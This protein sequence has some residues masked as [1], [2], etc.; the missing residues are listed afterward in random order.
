MF[1]IAVDIGGTFT[2]CVVADTD[3]DRTLS[4]SLTTHGSLSDGVLAA[5]DVN[6]T[7]RG[8]TVEALLR[9]TSLFVHGTTVGTNAVLT[10]TGAKT[11]LITTMGH[12]DAVIIGKVFSKRA[13]LS[14]RDVVH[15]SLLKKPAPLVSPE[16]IKG[17]AE[18][19]DVEGDVLVEL[20]EDAAIAA[21]AELVA[22]GVEAIAVSF[23]WSF[24]NPAHELRLK[25]LL[26]EHAPGVFVTI[27]SDLAPLLGEYERT[28]TAILNAYL[29]PKVDAYLVD[30]QAR[31]NA[32]G[33]SSPLLVMQSSGGL[34]T[35]ADACERPI[36]TLD[37]GPTGG[38]LGCAYLSELYG[39]PNVICTDVG[40]TS[41]ETGLV[42]GGEVPLEPAPVVAQYSYRL[43]K[44]G[45][46][47]VGAGGGGIAWLDEG[48]LLR[49]GPQSA[50]SMPG[51]ACYGR[52]GEA[53]T[54]T[55]ADLV[56]GYLGADSF[57]G[58]RMPLDVDAARTA[59]ARLGSQL[60]QE[61]EEVALGIFTIVNAHMADLIRKST[62]EQGHDPRGSVLVAYGGAGP[63][64]A[65]FYGKDIDAKAMLMLPDSSV[66]SAVGMLTCDITH[67]AE[68]SQPMASPF[69][70]EDYTRVNELLRQLERRVLDQF[71][72]EGVD[73]ADVSIRRSITVRYRSQ[74]HAVEIFTPDHDLSLADDDEIQKR[75]TDRY[76]QQYGQGSVYAAGGVEFD[77]FRVVGTRAVEPLR[78]RE[79]ESVGGDAS[80]AQCGERQVYFEASQSIST[81][82]FDD[83]LL[84][85]G[86]RIS[87]PAIIERPGDTVV[88]PPGFQAEV[89]PY[90]ALVVTPSTSEPAALVGAATAGDAR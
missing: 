85:A 59:L 54:V 74:V 22:D 60:G 71:A 11:G 49:V 31:L 19:V 45:V 51:P 48:G 63:M 78:F 73:S 5:L 43:P 52:G 50:G 55:D 89:D 47:S 14:E 17:I 72:G 82:I 44:V 77:G 32:A 76:V 12:E 26:A 39:E 37:S 84:Q 64:H 41:F 25:E 9:E 16:R 2:D 61:I 86:N 23:L 68:V 90:K 36:V 40:G 53:P 13:G 21:I 29:G 6:A 58:G 67:T 57:L 70:E 33:L 66:F 7:Q 42:I 65:V 10:R 81:A 1:R 3:G 24:I 38:V 83:S 35:V 27:A 80:G 75:F 69:S 56:L 79:H 8:T 15:A 28:V 30:L 87:G 88:V 62:I 34:T 20:D 46:R 18:R 4:K